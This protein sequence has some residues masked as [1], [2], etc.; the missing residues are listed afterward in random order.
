MRYPGVVD[1]VD[2]AVVDEI[3]LAGA[4][5][6]HAVA[7]A[8]VAPVAGRLDTAADEAEFAV[9]DVQSL[10]AARTDAVHADVHDAKVV[11]T[12]VLDAGVDPGG[13]AVHLDLEEALGGVALVGIE[14]QKA[15]RGLVVEF[16][17]GAKFVDRTAK[18]VVPEALFDGV[19][20]AAVTENV[21]DVLRKRV[22]V[23]PDVLFVGLFPFRRDGI[24]LR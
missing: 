7:V 1:V 9:G 8:G 3:I 16:E 15:A 14:V 5:D 11:E 20:P 24:V 2:V 17:V 13:L 22:L 4:V 19:Y 6:L 10:V 23:L 18:A 21:P 12:Q